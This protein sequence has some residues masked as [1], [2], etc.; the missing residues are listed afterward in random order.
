MYMDNKVLIEV[1]GLEKSFG[2]LRVLKGIDLTVKNGEV[3]ALLGPSGSGKTTLL[4]CLNFLEKADA[5]TLRIGEAAV[6]MRNISRRQIL[7]MRRKTAM[8][9]QNYDL[10][11]NKTVMENVTE[12][13]LTAR[14]V[15]KEE[16]LA[17]A[18]KV[19]EQVGLSDKLDARP[20]QLSGGQQQRAGIARALAVNPDVILFDEPTSALDPEKVKE[21]LDLIRA[22][23]K[24]GVTMIIVTHEME[25][26]WEAAGKIIF[27]DNGEIVEEGDP[28]QVF[29]SPRHERTKAFLSRFTGTKPPEYFI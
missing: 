11:L 6:D 14:G 27:M 16:A 23:A 29:G 2:P 22:V 19:L 15:P 17:R 13:L 8:V 5:G 1:R 18:E 7:S 12:G 26:A 4:R 24:S 25:F 3:A 9:F 21:I 28:K 10:F 20:Y